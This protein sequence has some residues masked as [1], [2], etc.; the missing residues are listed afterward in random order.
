MFFARTRADKGIHGVIAMVL[1]VL[2]PFCSNEAWDRMDRPR[3]VCTGILPPTFYLPTHGIF[4]LFI[5]YMSTP[6]N[7]QRGYH[8]I[9]WSKQEFLGF[10]LT[11]W[12]TIFHLLHN[13]P[14]SA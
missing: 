5:Y 4:Y 1:I 6:P 8:G 14:G 13:V 2:V 12:R 9:S 11:F 10:P 7:P 3:N